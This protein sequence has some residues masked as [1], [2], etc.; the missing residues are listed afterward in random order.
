MKQ[1]IRLATK[2]ETNAYEYRRRSLLR[3]YGYSYNEGNGG[4][5]LVIGLVV[6]AFWVL[7]FA[8]QIN[9]Y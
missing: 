2:K 3:S 8:W 7:W 5:Y 9:K 1:L 4:L 6:T